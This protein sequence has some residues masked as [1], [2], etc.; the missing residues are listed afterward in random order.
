M[1][2]GDLHFAYIVN[3]DG[4]KEGQEYNCQV[5]VGNS[6]SLVLTSI[7]EI[8]VLASEV[9]PSPRLAYPATAEQKRVECVDRSQ[10]TLTCIYGGK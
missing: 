6:P 7:H 3:E 9:R 5:G 2:I 8:K 1:Y 4:T 10:C